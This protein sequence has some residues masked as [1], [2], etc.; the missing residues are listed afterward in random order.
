MIISCYS[1]VRILQAPLVSEFKSFQWLNADTYL[2][3][4]GLSVLNQ[5]LSHWLP[6]MLGPIQTYSF[7]KDL[8]WLF[9]LN[10]MPFLRYPLP[11]ATIQTFQ[12][13]QS[14]SILSIPISLVLLYFLILLITFYSVQFAFLLSH[15][16]WSI[17]F[18]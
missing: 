2:T 13:H 12:F 8:Y 10:R 5:H 6:S 14:H 1:L 4:L 11:P 3:S 17:S 9:P 16:S 15:C 7:F 18:H